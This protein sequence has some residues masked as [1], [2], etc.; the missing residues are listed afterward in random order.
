MDDI[1]NQPKP[2]PTNITEQPAPTPLTPA[3]PGPRDVQTRTDFLGYVLVV[4]GVV[5]V[6]VLLAIVGGRALV[7]FAVI[8]AGIAA[9]HYWAWGRGLSKKVAEQRAEELRRQSEEGDEHLSEIER[10]RHY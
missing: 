9:F 1:T 2:T 6:T 5:V 7:S 3:E 10:P 8:I 4:L